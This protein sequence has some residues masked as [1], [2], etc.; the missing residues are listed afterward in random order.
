MAEAAHSV[1]ADPQRVGH[2]ARREWP[3]RHIGIEPLRVQ[4]GYS[5]KSLLTCIRLHWPARRLGLKCHIY[6]GL[7]RLAYVCQS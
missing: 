1:D 2:F 4:Q 3:L 6:R 5:K 7:R